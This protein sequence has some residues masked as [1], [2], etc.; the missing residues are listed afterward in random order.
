MSHD[1]FSKK[2]AA[3]WYFC[4]FKTHGFGKIIYHV[5]HR[6]AGGPGVQE[7]VT[8]WHKGGRVSKIGQ[9][10][11]HVLFEW[12]LRYIEKIRRSMNNELIKLG[13]SKSFHWERWI[14]MTRSEKSFYKESV[15]ET[16]CIFQLQSRMRLNREIQF[17]SLLTQFVNIGLVAL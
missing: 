9:E 2:L 13:I 15:V 4:L 1:I 3:F 8:K 6:G 12:P 10:K 16:I 11:C 17:L 14:P 5:T 7:N